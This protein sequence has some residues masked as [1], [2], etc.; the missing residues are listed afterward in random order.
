MGDID[1]ARK[2]YPVVR[3]SGQCSTSYGR[4]VTLIAAIPEATT[5]DEL[6]ADCAAIPSSLRTG[7]PHLPATG[8]ATP[9]EVDDACYAQVSELDEYV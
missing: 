2:H 3:L 5:F 8:A 4:G 7:N 9:W 6:I 1:R